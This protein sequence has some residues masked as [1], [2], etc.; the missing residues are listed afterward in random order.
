LA[1]NDI[2]RFYLGGAEAFKKVKIAW[3]AG[4]KQKKA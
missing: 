2:E 3:N 1:N 4:K